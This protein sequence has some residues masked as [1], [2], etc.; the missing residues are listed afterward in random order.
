MCSPT[1]EGISGTSSPLNVIPVSPISPFWFVR[2][3]TTSL[4]E[5]YGVAKRAFVRKFFGRE[6]FSKTFKQ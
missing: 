1:L 3:Q 4:N 6:I 5:R 2:A